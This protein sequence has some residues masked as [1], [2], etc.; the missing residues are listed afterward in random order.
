MR[1]SAAMSPSDHWSTRILDC[2]KAFDHLNE[3]Q[4]KRAAL[5]NASV[6]QAR[7]RNL[8]AILWLGGYYGPPFYSMG[9][10]R[11]LKDM[12]KTAGLI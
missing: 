5:Y 1:E 11:L 6:G 10:R 9:S 4:E 8:G 3:I 2:A 12:A 7:I